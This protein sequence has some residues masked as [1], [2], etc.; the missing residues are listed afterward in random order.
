MSD[1]TDADDTDEPLYD[2]AEPLADA[3][4]V[5]Q[6]LVVAGPTEETLIL[7]ADPFAPIDPSGIET[8]ER[9]LRVADRE[10]VVDGS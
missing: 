1:P 6:N 4:V 7:G 9:A 5:A 3:A 2:D 8:D 10:L